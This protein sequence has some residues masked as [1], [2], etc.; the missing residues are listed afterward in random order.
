V[1]LAVRPP[2]GTVSELTDNLG[3]RALAPP[4]H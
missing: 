4:M 3:D 2:S 1:T